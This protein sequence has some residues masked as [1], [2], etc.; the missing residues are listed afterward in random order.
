MTKIAYDKSL[1][2]TKTA[3]LISG[4][5]IDPINNRFIEKLYQYLF[6]FNI[7][8]VY[9]DIISEFIW[10]FDGIKTGK[11]FLEL[12]FAGPCII[13]ALLGTAKTMFL[14]WYKSLVQK[15]LVQL[16]AMH[17][18]ADEGLPS[19]DLDETETKIVKITV[20]YLNLV[21]LLLFYVSTS[22]IVAFSL[23][24]AI[25]MAYSYYKNGETEFLYPYPVKYF[26]NHATKERWPFV[27][28]HHVW[29]TVL[30][31]S[32][33]FGSDTLF[34]ALCAYIQM[35]FKLLCHHFE[36]MTTES[37]GDTRRQLAEYVV[38]HQELIKLVDQVEVLYSKST[39]FNLITSSI[40]ICLSGFNITTLADT[41][42]GILFSIFL[43][44]NLSQI[45]L[46]C[47]FGDL[48]MTSSTALTTAAYNSTWYDT[49]EDI[50]KCVLLVIVR[51][52]KPCKLTAAKFADVNMNAFT[53]IL[54]R[55]WS[56]FALLRT[57]YKE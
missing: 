19:I 2:L 40:L 49:H 1:S 44:M 16:S 20:K 29:S 56:Y 14:Y 4:I 23:M 28:A 52:Q 37:A 7:S 46:L 34:Y 6:Y 9:T 36:N 26:F 33:V 30:V 57:V 27:Y 22:V 25:M 32:F 8:F 41:S 50:K 10:V 43:Y 47:F 18:E 55:S 11:S 42:V 5:Q 39:L 38:R 51:T 31:G 53:T 3:L 24:P 13:I 54:S 17:P 21:I 45:S 15:I 48:I 35:H 12:S